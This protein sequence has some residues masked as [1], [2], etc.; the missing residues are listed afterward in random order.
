ME[1]SAMQQLLRRSADGTMSAA[2]FGFFAAPLPE[3][4]A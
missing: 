4:D 1:M 2:P 3:M